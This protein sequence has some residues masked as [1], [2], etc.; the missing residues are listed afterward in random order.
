MR[1]WTE[2]HPK[3]KSRLEKAVFMLGHVETTLH[4]DTYK[5]HSENGKKVYVVRVNRRARTSTCSCPDSGK[6]NHCKHRLV[7]ALFEKV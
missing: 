7:V 5:V 1:L 6:G 3:L 2:R 4:P